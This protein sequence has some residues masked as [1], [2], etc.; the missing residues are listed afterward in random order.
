VRHFLQSAEVLLGCDVDRERGVVRYDGRD[1]HVGAHSISIDVSEAEALAGAMVPGRTRPLDAPVEILSVDRL[2]YTKG[3][4]RRLT[5]IERVLEHHPARRLRF[6]QVLVPSRER[7][8]DYSQLK[9]EIDQA[10]G[11]VNGRFSAGGWSPVRYIARPVPR[12]DL[13][14]MYRQADVALV[15]P[16]RDGMNLVAKEY[17][18]SQLDDSGVLIL[19]EMAG[20]AEE[21]QEALIVNPFHGDAVVE[22]I[23]R[24]LS[25]PEQERRARMS[26][27][28]A[29]VK[30]RDVY[31]WVSDF[32][33]AAEL[34]AARS[35]ASSSP[36]LD[37]VIS[38]VGPWL[39]ERQRVSLL[40]DFDGTITPIVD[41]PDAA[42]LSHASRLAIQLQGGQW[43]TIDGIGELG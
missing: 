19:S 16:L 29:R 8:P 13:F 3:I 31:A 34:A 26:A 11:R 36:A 28:R 35:R 22:A 14:A 15:T 42:R 5:A 12:E 39:G 4:V 6:T 41:R 23:Q 21:L 20:A 37:E 38:R 32:M 27:L 1:V 33:A 24:A 30:S 18:A 43:R 7:V 10:V 25:M 17:V 40:L 9:R 2:D